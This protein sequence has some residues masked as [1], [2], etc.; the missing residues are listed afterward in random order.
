MRR[1]KSR[2][3]QLRH[4]CHLY[5]T[6]FHALKDAIHIVDTRTQRTVF[7]NQAHRRRQEEKL[8]NVE[9]GRESAESDIGTESLDME[10][11]CIE[12]ST[13]FQLHVERICVKEALDGFFNTMPQIVWCVLITIFL[14]IS[15]FFFWFV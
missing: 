13:D 9:I 7:A 2:L 15:M 14:L 5:E 12:L 1:G 8:Q 11:E 6:A 10:K 4:R 3:A